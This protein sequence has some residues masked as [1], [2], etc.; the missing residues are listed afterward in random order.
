MIDLR[1]YFVPV[2]KSECLRPQRK[3]HLLDLHFPG[4]KLVSYEIT[5]FRPCQVEQYFFPSVLIYF[6]P[7]VEVILISISTRERR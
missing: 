1:E 4:N 3:K 5:N 2:T 6:W 7:T